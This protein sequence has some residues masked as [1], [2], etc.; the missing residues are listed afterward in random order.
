MQY[1]KKTLILPPMNAKNVHL[2]YILVFLTGFFASACHKDEY[3]PRQP[4]LPGDSL[5]QTLV[6][7]MVGENSLHSDLQVDS[8]EIAWGLDS[9][10][11][12]ARV[13][14][15]MD[16][17]KGS[18]LCVGRKWERL[19]VIK[20]YE[21]NLCSTDSQT[22]ANVFDDIFRRYPARHY[23]LAMCSHGS[24]WL[25]DEGQSTHSGMRRSFGLDNGNRNTTNVGRRMP[26]TALAG[27]LSGCP[28]FDYI[29]FDACFMQC[30]EVAYEL[31]HAADYIIA[32]PAEIPATGAPYTKLMRDLCAVP[33]QPELVTRGYV[34]YYLTGDGSKN[35]GGAE[36]SLIRTD[37]LEQ[38]AQVTAPYLKK[39][40]AGR[41]EIPIE[42]V[43]SFYPNLSSDRYTGY[44][45]LKNLFYTHLDLASY[46][47]WVRVFDAAVPVQ[48]LSPKW[49]SSYNSWNPTSGSFQT[50]HD[51][52]HTGG[53]SVYVPREVDVSKGWTMDYH[54]LQWYQDTGLRETN[55]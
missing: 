15:F 37:R 53:V 31:R 52:P 9:I 32:S 16:D 33:A 35:Y 21:E 20:T 7:Y 3:V 18:R 42:G 2:I 24:G 41:K 44:I 46:A 1:E 39:L 8:L 11:K 28:H 48:A 54:R 38:L 13:V 49:Y 34:D 10:S 36:L 50:V 14:V 4:G 26:I 5:E 45:D 6:V 51:I 55:W 30:I 17:M 19:Q 25:F 47:S 23:G 12:N 27:V 43:Q 29:L 40:M 22:M